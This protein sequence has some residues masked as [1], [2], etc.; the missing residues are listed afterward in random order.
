[1]DTI[2][3]LGQYATI[4]TPTDLF[5]LYTVPADTET[6]ISHLNVCNTSSADT[7]IWVSVAK[8][9]DANDVSHS[10]Y[11]EL[12]VTAKNTFVCME[13]VTVSA[14]DIVRIAATELGVAFN[15]F[16]EENS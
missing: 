3:I 6:C 13:G 1:M 2:K 10:L 5:D 4:G 8:D 16:G 11:Y 12:E 9:G 14:G 7:N 15:L